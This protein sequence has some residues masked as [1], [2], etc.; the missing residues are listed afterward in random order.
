[1]DIIY[2]VFTLVLFTFVVLLALATSRFVSVRRRDVNPKLFVLMAGYEPPVYV[3]K[4]TRN[5]ANLL[6]IPMFF[7][8]LAVLM[9]TLEIND[10][11]LV[12]LAWLF[13]GTRILH[14]AIHITYNH[15]MQR[16]GV[17]LVSA[18]T[19]LVMWIRFIVILG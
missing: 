4:L 18:I 10:P 12:N 17:F 1:M 9:I 8:L 5:F 15:V 6:E 14:S 19:L 16:F 3:Q 7:Y 13:V 11:I 2:P